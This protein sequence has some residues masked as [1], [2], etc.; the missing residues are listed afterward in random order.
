MGMESFKQRLSEYAVLT[1]NT[2]QQ[3]LPEETEDVVTEAMRYS[4]LA[5]GKRLR[6]ALALEFCLAF[7]GSKG[8]RASLCLRAGNGARLFVDS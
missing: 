4:L 8:G 7:G 5:G 1:E 2:L 6:C 3:Y